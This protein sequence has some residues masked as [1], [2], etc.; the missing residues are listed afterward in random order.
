VLEQ[1]APKLVKSDSDLEKQEWEGCGQ[2]KLVKSE[3]QI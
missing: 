1:A 2:S 3:T